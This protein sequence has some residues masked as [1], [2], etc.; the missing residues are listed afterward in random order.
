MN[1]R[2]MLLTLATF[3]TGAQAAAKPAVAIHKTPGAG[4]AR[5]GVSAAADRLSGD[6]A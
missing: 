1:R 3:A 4:A 2:T 5:V 6:A